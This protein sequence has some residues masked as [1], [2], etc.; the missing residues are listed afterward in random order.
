MHL[1]EVALFRRLPAL[2]RALP[3][4]R[5]GG[6][7]TPVERLAALSTELGADVWVK[8]EDRSNLRYGGNKVR[9]LEAVLGR[10][11]AAGATHIWATGAYGSNHAVATVMHAEAAGLGAGVLLFPQPASDPARAN[12]AA[13]I[14][15]GPRIERIASVALLPA[16]MSLLARR[17]RASGA[18]PWIMPPG[19]ASPEGAVGALTAAFELAEQ[20]AEG[21]CPAPRRIVLAVGSTC[22]TAGVL[23]GLHL[24]A[25]LGVGFTRE[26]LPEV[27]AVRVTPWPVTSPWRIANLARRTLA[28]VDEARGASSGVSIAALRRTVNV[29][30]AYFGGGYGRSTARGVRAAVRFADSGGPPLDIVYSAKAGAA[31]CDLAPHTDGP[32]LFWATKSSAVLPVPTAADLAGAAPELRAYLATAR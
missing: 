27:C 5:L 2:G 32:I 9:T 12:L 31:L 10:A 1:D 19:G 28:L 25:A 30:G 6:W 23:A 16:A 21:S 20:V 8:R 7:P 11:R 29:L 26:T 3:W 17:E 13:M 4:V 15:C 22:T 24:A 18:V 14:A